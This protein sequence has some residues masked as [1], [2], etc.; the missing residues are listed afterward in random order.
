MRG[1]VVSS[2]ACEGLAVGMPFGEAIRDSGR[3]ASLLDRLAGGAVGDE[4]LG[5]LSDLLRCRGVAQE[6]LHA[7]AQ[8]VRLRTVG[9]GVYL[10]GLVELSNRCQKDC[11]YCGIRRSNRASH[12]YDLPDEAVVEAAVRSWRAGYG[13]LALQSGERQGEAF[14][15][16][17]EGLVSQIMAA[18]D[19]R[20]GI[21]LSLGEQSEA[22]YW[23]WRRAGATRYLLRIESSTF[24][25]YRRLH[26]ADRMHSFLQRQRALRA[27]RAC[28]YQVGSGVMIGLPG[29]SECDLAH[30]LVW[31]AGSGIDMVGMGPYIPHPGTPLGAALKEGDIPSE[32]ER[33]ELSLNMVALLRIVAPE[34]NIAAT[35]ALQALDPVGRDRALGCGANVLMPNVTP[36][37]VRDLYALYSG[38]PTTADDPADGLSELQG[39]VRALGLEIGLGETGN[40]LRYRR[41]HECLEERPEE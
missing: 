34:I 28:D 6:V 39:R 10:R 41:R 35:T 18:T 15:S 24:A 16:R 19:G 13:S 17:I 27:L 14:A 30:D 2:S 9:R 36:G 4:R 33:L 21:T 29:Q 11:Y 25:L 12:R 26:P 38:K 37:R 22:T 23:V 20:F 5:L 32:S 3:A 40:S 1:G 8:D 31:L 7:Y